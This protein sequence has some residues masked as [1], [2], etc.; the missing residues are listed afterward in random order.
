MSLFFGV[1]PAFVAAPW[2]QRGLIRKPLRK[3][4]VICCT[5]SSATSLVSLRWCSASNL[6]VAA[7]CS[8]VMVS[9]RAEGEGCC[10]SKAV[11]LS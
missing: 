4:S 5:T 3:I 6:C 8:S 7:S 1:S 11:C 9:L 2:Y 10:L